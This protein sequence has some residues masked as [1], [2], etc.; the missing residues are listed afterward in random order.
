MRRLALLTVAAL[1][2]AGDADAQTCLGN[3]SLAS[4]P[5]NV[6]VSGSYDANGAGGGT[7]ANIGWFGGRLITGVNA[8]YNYLVNP[9]QTRRSVGL[10]LAT[11]RDTEE[12]LQ[13]CPYVSAR[14]TVGDPFTGFDGVEGRVRFS[15]YSVGVG[16]GGQLAP[17][18]YVSIVPWGLIQLQRS[19]GTF[20]VL[21]AVDGE[22][23]ED[24]DETGG[25]FTFGLGFRFDEWLQAS[26]TIS[27]SSFAGADLVGGLR[28]SMALRPKRR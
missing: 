1:M 6:G 5:I 10:T 26:P 22:T 12:V 25:I 14:T 28:V 20:E 24:L 18:R 17:D 3:P 15:S 21:R 2:L 19:V 13:F 4:G 9:E 27:V 23:D 7:Q 8:A 16:F 11:Q